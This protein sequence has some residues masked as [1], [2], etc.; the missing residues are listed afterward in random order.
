MDGVDHNSWVET[1][2]MLC[3]AASSMT[4]RRYIRK[5]VEHHHRRIF[6]KRVSSLS[7]W[8]RTA[9]PMCVKFEVYCTSS[10]G[11]FMWYTAFSADFMCL[12]IS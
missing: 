4:L 12:Q 5:K 3:S 1:M 6:M 11:F 9:A 7:S 10:A 2:A 8:R